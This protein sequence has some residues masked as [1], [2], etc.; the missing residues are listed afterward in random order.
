MLSTISLTD[1][2]NLDVSF[3]ISPVIAPILREQ[4]VFMSQCFLAK[5]SFLLKCF[6]VVWVLF[7]RSC[8]I[9]EFG[10]DFSVY[11]EASESAAQGLMV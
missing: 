9:L 2:F 4:A 1:S 10:I 6:L 11:M 7:C 8:W 5:L 3:K